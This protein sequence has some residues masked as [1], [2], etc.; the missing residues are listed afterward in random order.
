MKHNKELFALME[1][2]H[3][4]NTCGVGPSKDGKYN[5]FAFSRFCAD[6]KC[7]YIANQPEQLEGR[8]AECAY[9][10]G[11]FKPSNVELAF[12][13]YLPGNEKDSFYCGCYGWD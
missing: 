7:G 6:C 11:Q 3:A 1:C 8:S 5:N 4:V 2:G 12:F 9:G 13:E 10:C